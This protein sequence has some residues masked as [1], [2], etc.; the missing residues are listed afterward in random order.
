[1]SGVP[2]FVIASRVLTGLQEQVTLEAVI[3]EQ[4]AASQGG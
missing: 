1:V 2:M 3:E 4:T